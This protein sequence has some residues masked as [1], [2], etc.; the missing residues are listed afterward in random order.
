M[1]ILLIYLYYKKEYKFFMIKF[2]LNKK[3]LSPIFLC[4]FLPFT[5]AYFL[6]SFFNQI[7][8]MLAPYL[9]QDLHL[10]AGQL[11][12]T[13]SIYLLVFA[14]AQLPVGVFLD[15]FGPRKVQSFLFLIAALGILIFSSATNPYLLFVGRGLIGIG[16]SSGLMSGFRAMRSWL[17]KE[18]IPLANGSLM[19]AG[20]LGA[21]FSTVPVEWALQVMSWRYLLIGVIFL[22]L[23]MSAWI[24]VSVPDH[25]SHQ[26]GSSLS[27]RQQLLEVKEI[28]KSSYFWRIAPLVAFAFGSNMSIVGLWAGPWLSDVALLNRTEI[29][30]H[31]LVISIALVLGIALWGFIADRVTIKLNQ[32][33]TRVIGIGALLY[34]FIQFLLI[35]GISPGS[36]WIWFAFGL[37]SRCTTLAYAA[38]SQHFH[39]RYAG[40]ATTAL[41]MLFFLTAFFTQVGMGM[42]I[43]IWPKDSSGHYSIH[44][45]HAAFMGILLLQVAGYI[46]FCVFRKSANV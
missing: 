7:N 38:V 45:Y 3:S 23:I 30:Y 11:G 26:R 18:K 14:I 43:D 41:N 19:A 34:L 16:M 13:T 12:L 10:S 6:T 20:T 40:R 8:A 35:I 15:H 28:F 33:I 9:F 5:G 4:V 22:T 24:F 2:F 27:I 42:I 25:P 39:F 17:P 1:R 36:Y 44:G 21:I 46:W 29:A 37:L 32:P 31:L